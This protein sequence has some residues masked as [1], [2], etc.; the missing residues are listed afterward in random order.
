MESGDRLVGVGGE[1]DVTGSESV[2][3]GSMGAVVELAGASESVEYVGFV[4]RSSVSFD[5]YAVAVPSVITDAEEVIV[6]GGGSGAAR[7]LSVGGTSVWLEL[8]DASGTWSRVWSATL[9]EGSYSL[10]GLHV[11]F[12]R[13]DVAGVRFGSEPKAGPSFDGWGEVVLHF[14]RA[15]GSGAV[16]VSASSVLEA[17]A[18]SRFRCLRGRCR[19]LREACL[20]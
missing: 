7:A 19:C 3:V 9:G 20:T 1:V 13:Q 6:V 15:V 14:G 8:Q 18:G 17:V 16:R 5:E 12:D 4:W 10:D 2:R 11:G